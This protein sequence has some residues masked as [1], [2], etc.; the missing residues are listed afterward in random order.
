MKNKLYVL[1]FMLLVACEAKSPIEVTQVSS[2]EIVTF[3]DNY[4]D[5]NTKKD[6]IRMSIPIEFEIKI[7]SSIKYITWIYIVNNKILDKDYFDYEVYNKESKTKPIRQLDFN[8]LSDDS[9]TIVLKERNHLISR[10]DALKL[11]QKYNINKSVDNLKNNDTI[12]LIRYDEFR[13]NNIEIINDFKKINDS[14]KFKIMRKDGKFF[15][16]NKKINW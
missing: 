4:L 10:K 9:I 6:S 7:K 14:I 2:N 15:Y 12:K 3:E 5:R 11:L 13:K 1:A 16:V 8:E